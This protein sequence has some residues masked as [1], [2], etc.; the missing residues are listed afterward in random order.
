MDAFLKT[1]KNC[2]ERE[3][4]IHLNEAF[5]PCT[6]CGSGEFTFTEFIPGSI[7]EKLPDE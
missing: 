3:V 7:P 2:Y 6:Y 4:V 5:P 1:C